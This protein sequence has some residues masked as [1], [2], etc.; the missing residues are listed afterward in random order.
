[1]YQCDVC[2]GEFEPDNISEFVCPCCQDALDDCPVCGCDDVSLNWHMYQPEMKY[3]YVITCHGCGFEMQS[4]QTAIMVWPSHAKAI[5]A[6]WAQMV[7]G[8]GA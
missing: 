7:A 6:R 4:E 2:D 3:G 8:F 5:T 1:M